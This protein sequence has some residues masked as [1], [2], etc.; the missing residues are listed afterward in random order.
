MGRFL[1]LLAVLMQQAAIWQKLLFQIYQSEES[2]K[3]TINAHTNS[4][5]L[6]Q[7]PIKT[8]YTLPTLDYLVT[9][10]AGEVR[11]IDIELVA[12]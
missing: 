12:L 7:L 11:T 6:H 2:I 9:S 8:A 4:C 10:R 3:I 1:M 5:P